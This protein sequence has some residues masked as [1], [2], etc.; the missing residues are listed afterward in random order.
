M[1]PKHLDYDS[2]YEL[3]RD[4]NTVRVLF[5]CFLNP[6]IQLEPLKN[7]EMQI[8]TLCILFTL[9]LDISLEQTV[10]KPELTGSQDGGQD[11]I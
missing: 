4:Y 3:I 10:P 2:G 8:I 9:I 6:R 5:I 7:L 1:D 11:K